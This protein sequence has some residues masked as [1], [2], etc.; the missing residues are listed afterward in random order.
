MELP[1]L[2]EHAVKSVMRFV[3]EIFGYSISVIVGILVVIL[4]S[5]INRFF[6]YM[7]LGFLQE[8]NKRISEINSDCLELQGRIKA[9]AYGL[10]RCYNG[11]YFSYASDEKIHV[12]RLNGKPK[13]FMP[14]HLSRSHFN[15]FFVFSTEYDW[16]FLTY[17][18]IKKIDPNSPLLV[19]LEEHKVSAVYIHKLSDRD[20]NLEKIYGF[21]IYAWKQRMTDTEFLANFNMHER[22]MLDSIHLRF[23]SY[24]ESSIFEKFGIRRFT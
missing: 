10:I 4:R 5:E 6:D 23:I 15:S 21:V 14:S 22:R 12:I 24:I 18:D 20:K 7:G 3:G 19:I 11:K 16:K 13:S 17:D 2:N 8:A 1:E 9:D